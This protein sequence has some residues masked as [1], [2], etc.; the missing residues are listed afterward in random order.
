MID[1]R[2]TKGSGYNGKQI[3]YNVICYFVF[4]VLTQIN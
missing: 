4:L 1:N 3:E 2:I